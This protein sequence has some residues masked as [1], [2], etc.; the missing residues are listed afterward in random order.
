MENTPAPS[1]P[2]SAFVRFLSGTG[3]TIWILSFGILILFLASVD[4]TRFGV[5]LSARAYFGSLIAIWTYPDEWPM[6]SLLSRIWLPLPGAPVLALAALV[7]LVFAGWYRLRVQ[8]R[9]SS[10]NAGLAVIHVGLIVV[11][12]GFF[13]LIGGVSRAVEL[14]EAGAVLVVVGLILHQMP[15]LILFARESVH[16]DSVPEGASAGMRLNRS[17]FFAPVIGMATGALIAISNGPAEMARVYSETKLDLLPILLY[18]PTLFIIAMYWRGAAKGSE[19]QRR[20]AFPLLCSA[21][22]LHSALTVCLAVIRRLP[23]VIDLHSSIVC[24][25]W[26]GALIAYYAERRRRDGLAGA[27]SAVVGILSLGIAWFVSTDFSRQIEP[28]I[29]SKLWLIL[30]VGTITAAYGAVLLAVVLADICLFARILRRDESLSLRIATPLAGTIGAALCL[31]AAGILMGGLWAQGAWGRF[32]GWDPKENAALMLLFACALI[33]H[34]RR[35]GQIRARG[36]VNLTALAGLILAW[37]WAGTNLMGVGLHS[38]GF[39]S[40]GLWIT[41]GYAIGQSALVAVA[42]LVP[43][44]PDPELE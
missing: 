32:W 3:F 42:A 5:D 35:G 18:A 17:W 2:R 7:N 44:A 13:S 22:A 28:V 14:T 16:L 21:I 30:H 41:I 10:V 19:L 33:L 20:L 26:A 40:P 6:G 24:A 29:A 25:G 4:S 36:L 9:E 43:L 8:V 23:P 12:A 27:A 15:R 11:V 38:Y 37:S 39:T 31:L 1:L 34:A